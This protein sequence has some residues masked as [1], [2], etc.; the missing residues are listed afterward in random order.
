[1]PGKIGKF[2]VIRT[3]GEGSTCKVKLAMDE[4]TGRKV[5]IK[6]LDPKLDQ[7]MKELIMVEVQAMSQL[8][9]KNIVELIEVG[10]APYEKADGSSS[11]VSYIVLENAH[12][13]ELF[14]FIANSSQFTEAEARY[15]FKQFMEGLD[16]CHNR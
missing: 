13:G 1:M 15:F 6:I 9:H 12:G 7:K 4:T 14:D 11:V 3:L 2:K 5:A 16:F 8:K 10:T